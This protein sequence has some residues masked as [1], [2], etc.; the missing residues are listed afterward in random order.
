MTAAA[1][2]GLEP[3]LTA[4]EAVV[5]PLDESA[6]QP[7]NSLKSAL[8]QESVDRKDD[9]G[10]RIIFMKKPFLPVLVLLIIVA[11]GFVIFN[12][13]ADNR[14]SEDI[15]SEE[16]MLPPMDTS[17]WKLEDAS[18]VNFKYPEALNTAYIKT[19]DWPPKLNIVDEEL[20][21]MDAGEET[22]RGGQ[23]SVHVIN[24]R[25]YCVTTVTDA[26]AGSVYRQYAYAF[27]KD[28][29]NMILTFSLRSPQCE[30]YEEPERKDCKIKMQD[31]NPDILVDNIVQTIENK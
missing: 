8:I 25:T 20:S 21:C 18:E 29:K 7:H 17:A 28:D 10:D 14:N 27:S 23:T 15:V 1:D 4:P 5:L 3:Q 11:G 24:G 19:V 12:K 9:F 16:E 30:N 26:A 22:D 2:Q 6:I 13:D 31:F